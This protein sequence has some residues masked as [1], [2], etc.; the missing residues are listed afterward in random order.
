MDA[1]LGYWSRA[2]SS[3]LSGETAEKLRALGYLH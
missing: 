2:E 1:E 3:E